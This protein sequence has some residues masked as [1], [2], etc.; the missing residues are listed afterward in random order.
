MKDLLK[1][2]VEKFNLP[3][4]SRPN[5]LLESDKKIFEVIL[6]LSKLKEFQGA[7]IC[8]D[9]YFDKDFST[10]HKK[11]YIFLS[12][13]CNHPEISA[14]VF[15]VTHSKKVVECFAQNLFVIHLGKI[16]DESKSNYKDSLLTSNIYKSMI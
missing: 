7:V 11:L 15:I 8:F 12:Y 4:L 3:K 2:L 5:S 1:D 13:L 9:E 6:G 16:F 14:Q 10:T